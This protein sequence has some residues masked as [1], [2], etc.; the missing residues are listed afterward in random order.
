[1]YDSG[2]SDIKFIHKPGPEDLENGL[3][4][5][6]GASG[7]RVCMDSRRKNCIYYKKFI[8]ET[9]NYKAALDL[10]MYPFKKD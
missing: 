6:S 7:L 10:C 8:E 2:C 3:P 5:H 4:K 9:E 1:M